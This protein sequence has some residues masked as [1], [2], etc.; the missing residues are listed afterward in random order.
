MK[1]WKQFILNIQK[2]WGMLNFET[3]WKKINHGN[4]LNCFTAS[5]KIIFRDIHCYC[6]GAGAMKGAVWGAWLWK[7]GSP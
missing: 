7:S 1:N 6:R 3:S 5:F 2:G 4:S